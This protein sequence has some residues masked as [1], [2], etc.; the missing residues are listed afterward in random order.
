MIK[1][2]M[3]KDDADLAKLAFKPKQQIM[4]IG[5]AGPLPERPKTETVFLEDMDD[6]E[7]ALAVRPGRLLRRFAFQL[8]TLT[9]STCS[10]SRRSRR[11]RQLVSSTL[12]TR[13]ILRPLPRRCGRSLR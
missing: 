7:L 9:L 6:G 8:S 11:G 5:T 4:V 1:G 10:P 3:L 2:G 12:A 13:V